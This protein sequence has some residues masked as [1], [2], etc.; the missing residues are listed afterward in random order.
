MR[1]GSADGLPTPRTDS[2]IAGLSM[3]AGDAT[4]GDL[5]A[6][7]AGCRTAGASGFI[8]GVSLCRARSAADRAIWVAVLA[9]CTSRLG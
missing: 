2:A 3:L 5:M 8:L 1:A 7:R 4:M 9:V 6:V